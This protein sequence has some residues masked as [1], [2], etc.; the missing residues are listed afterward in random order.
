[1]ASETKRFVFRSR[2]IDERAANSAAWGARA[3]RPQPLDRGC[4]LALLWYA[5]CEPVAGEQ[6][7]SRARHEEKVLAKARTSLVSER[8]LA[9]RGARFATVARVAFEATR[10]AAFLLYV[11]HSLAWRRFVGATVKPVVYLSFRVAQ[12]WEGCFLGWS[13]DGPSY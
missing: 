11:D 1:M 10:A 12:L 8:S 3:C 13:T 6:A 4:A 7:H 5:Q 2:R 9:S